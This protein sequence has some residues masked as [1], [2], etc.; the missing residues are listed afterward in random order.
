[1]GVVCRRP[2]IM[3]LP[4]EF[5]RYWLFLSHALRAKV[6]QPPPYPPPGQREGSDTSVAPD[7]RSEEA[8]SSTHTLVARNYASKHPCPESEIRFTKSNGSA[9]S[10]AESPPVQ[11][12]CRASQR[13]RCFR[14]ALIP[15]LPLRL[16]SG[17]R[18]TGMTNRGCSFY[19]ILSASAPGET[20]LSR[21]N[22]SARCA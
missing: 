15:R 8:E 13:H 9:F 18:L 22:E 11:I 6:R 12:G 10:S 16:R 20:K 2:Y 21:A 7:P 4:R 17:L 19:V 1:M 5:L 14:F 3:A